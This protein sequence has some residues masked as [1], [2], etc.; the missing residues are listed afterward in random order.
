MKDLSR[1]TWGFI[2]LSGLVG[3]M[4][5]YAT[6][7]E[8]KPTTKPAPAPTQPAK[9]KPQPKKPDPPCPH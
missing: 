6:V 2:L 9:P 3:G 4:L 8:K 7:N 1:M 5:Y